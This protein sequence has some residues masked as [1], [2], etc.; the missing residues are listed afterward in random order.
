L[1]SEVLNEDHAMRVL[2]LSNMDLLKQGWVGGSEGSKEGR[3]R[4]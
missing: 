3:E 4:K 1:G 2:L